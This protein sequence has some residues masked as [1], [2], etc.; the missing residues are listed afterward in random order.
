MYIKIELDEEYVRLIGDE[1]RRFCGQLTQSDIECKSVN[2]MRH[3]LSKQIIVSTFFSFFSL[4]MF[5]NAV[6]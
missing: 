4:N 1:T 5:L 2:G 3:S 6:M